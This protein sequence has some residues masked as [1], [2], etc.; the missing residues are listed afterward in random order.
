MIRCHN[1]S[2]TNHVSKDQDIKKTR[3]RGENTE[4]IKEGDQSNKVTNVKKK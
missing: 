2:S 4:F 1:A 3:G